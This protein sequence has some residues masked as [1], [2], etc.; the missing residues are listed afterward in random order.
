MLQN[1]LI[2]LPELSLLTFILAAVPVN[3]Y[4]VS[5]T[6]KTFFTLSKVFLLITLLSTVIF[7][8]KS[9]FPDWWKNTSY[10]TLFKTVIYLI[11]LLWFYLS[12]KW[13]LNKD[14][15]SFLFYTLVMVELLFFEL[16]LS[17]QNLLLPAVL[18]PLIC[19]FNW[20]LLKL[21]RDE[22]KV[23]AAAKL[24]TFFST[25]F[26][27]LLWGGIALFYTYCG[28]T[29]F[30]AVQIYLQ[31]TAEL[32]LGVYIAAGMIMASLLFMLAAAPFHSCFIGI[33]STAIL[34]VCGFM[35]LIPPFVFLS[36][37]IN[38]MVNVFGPLNDFIRP[39]LLT[40]GTISL[41]IG[42]LSA[43]YE[44][45]MRRLFAFSSVYN[46]GFM[47]FSV[48]SFNGDAVLSAFAY[49]VIYV[50]AMAG[51]YTVFLGIKSRGEYL[52]CLKDISGLSVPKPYIS[53]AFLV[54]MVSL[55]GI[56]PL[57]GFLGRL[58]VINNLIVEGLWSHV[59]I[60]LLAL[61]FMANAYLQIIRTIYFETPKNNFDRT[62]K[63]I[64]I[65]LFINLVL[66]M[67]SIL[68]PGWLLNDAEKILRSVF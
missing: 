14:S 42:A 49:T 8:N 58:S 40:F 19:W 63:A 38:L 68:N 41:L 54:F 4:R 22:E 18:V 46:I 67:M 21:R 11:S 5:K 35:T 16:L 1:W 10:T 64:Y 2:L 65:S 57:L 51:V 60:L 7:Y 44:N 61:L 12:S 9:A 28:E 53:A 17:A 48:V 33:I 59:I 20:L 66:V 47:L 3:H 26:T 13:F 39:V 32:P 31:Q 37:L 50:L 27:L 56:P 24:Y 34:P 45:N 25:L 30:A 36:C 43:N 15:S 6:P 23:T 52:V 62:D 29:S 55:I